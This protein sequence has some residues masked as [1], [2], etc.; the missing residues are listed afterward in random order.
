V[1][2]Y[3]VIDTASPLTVRLDSGDAV[4]P[5]KCLATYTPVADDRVAVV[6]LGAGL[7]VLGKVLP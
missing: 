7:L 4:L 2:E 5:A 3:G 6:R 1:S